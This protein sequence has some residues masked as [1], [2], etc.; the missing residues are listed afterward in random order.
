MPH[1]KGTPKTPGSGRKVGTSNKATLTVRALARSFVDDPAYQEALRAR[2]LDGTAGS[3][4]SLLWG[5]A[6]GRVP[7]LSDDGDQAR[8]SITITF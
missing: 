3:M 5:Y 7:V 8:T 4:E 6:Y 1:P 2:L